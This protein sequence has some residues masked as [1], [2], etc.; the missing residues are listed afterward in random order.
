MPINYL[1][2]IAYKLINSLLFAVM[3]LIIVK[4]LHEIPPI[5][6]LFM[7]AVLGAILC[8]ILANILQ[9]PIIIK[10]QSRQLKLYMWRAIVNLAAMFTWIEALKHIPISEATALAYIGPVWTLLIAQ[11]LFAERFNWTCVCIVI[12]NFIGVL[13]ILQPS[14]VDTNW[15]GVGIALLCTGLWAW[16][17]VICKKQSASEHYVLQALYNSIFGA[18]LAAPLAFITWQP[19]S[20]THFG[21]VSL[22]S[23][24]GVVN[25]MALFLSYVHAPLMLLAPFSYARLLFVVILAY[26]FQ[27]IT[28]SSGCLVGAVIILLS[29]ILK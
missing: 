23:A 12:L 24:I 17:E 22:F 4:Y 16:H 1:R 5:Q 18:V 27:N 3:S 10:W 11:L 13:A 25:L 8:I 15:L 7:R 14:W 9:L 29:N 2:G 26:F 21:Y 28:P 19:I 6:F 20:I